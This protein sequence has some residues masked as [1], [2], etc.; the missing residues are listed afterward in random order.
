LPFPVFFDKLLL[1]GG[2]TDEQVQ[3]KK[4]QA[5]DQKQKQEAAYKQKSGRAQILINLLYIF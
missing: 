2:E 4:A 5:P 3:T 1:T